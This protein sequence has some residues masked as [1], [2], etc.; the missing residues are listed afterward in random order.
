MRRTL[1]P[2]IIFV[3]LTLFIG[4][5]ITGCGSDSKA[6]ESTQTTHSEEDHQLYTC[7]MHPNVIQEGPGNC[8]ICGMNLTPLSGESESSGSASKP[9]GD[10]KILYWQAPMDPSYIRNEPG[11]SP[12]GMDLVPVYEGE[13]AFG[14]TVKI[15][16]VIEQNM[17]IRKAQVERRDLT[18]SIRTV[19][20]IETDESRVS[21]IHTKISGWVEKTYVATTGEKVEKD[22]KLLEIY[23]PQLV[24]AQD[25]YLDAYHNVQLLPQNSDPVLKQNLENV[26]HSV[27][28]RLEYFDI[29]DDQIRDLEQSGKIKKTLVIRSPYDGFVITKHVLDGMEVRPGMQLYTIADLTTL[30][31]QAE[32]YESELPWVA[33]GQSA[34]ITL[35][36]FP[37]E[38]FS[39]V[40]DYIYPVLGTKSRTITVRV[41]AVNPDLRLKPGMYA[42][43][44]LQADP[45]ENAVA[46][47][48]EAVLFSGERTLVFV[49]L[50]NGR[51]APRDV[52]VGIESGDDY[53]EIRDGLSPGETIV[54]SGQFLLDSESRLQEGIAKM[55]AGRKKGTTDDS[56]TKESPEME[57]DSQM[58]MDDESAQDMDSMN[59]SDDA[60]EIAYYTC[61]MSEHSHIKEDHPGK[62]PECGMNLVP[63][64]T[65][66][67][68]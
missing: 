62:C 12:M 48:Q 44:T 8:P 54:L 4:L 5:G 36:Y 28:T 68:E 25:E 22:E 17:G 27:R 67:A 46:V 15:N 40:V 42:N 31:I 32:I 26:L 37:G 38:A 66:E 24:T 7:G 57:M 49:A 35:P 65:T 60:G 23:S 18:K 10:K 13:E 2:K 59:G 51:F 11:K 41:V 63:V 14:S 29:S 58:E 53:Y 33:E 20:R 64:K 56:M 43:V 61:P 6:S 39:G 47:P 30:W 9:A 1:I 50:G 21:H 34:T 45:V 16:P 55:L 3:G 52:T 19:A